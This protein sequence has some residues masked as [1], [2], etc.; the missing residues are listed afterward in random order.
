ME[1]QSRRQNV[2]VSVAV[3]IDE[4][5]KD[6]YLSACGKVNVLEII[7]LR[8]GTTNDVRSASL[9]TNEVT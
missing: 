6:D 2:A 7:E 1:L 8:I 9:C 5:N 3:V 4:S